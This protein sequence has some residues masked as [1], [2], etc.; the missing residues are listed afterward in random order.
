[1]ISVCIHRRQ[2]APRGRWEKVNGRLVALMNTA[3]SSATSANNF[4]RRRMLNTFSR[5]S[6]LGQYELLAP[7]DNSRR[8]T[9]RHTRHWCLRTRLRIVLLSAFLVAPV[10]LV[11]TLNSGPR[12]QDVRLFEERLPQ[13]DTSNI[14]KEGRYLRFEGMLTGKGFNNVLQE[15]WVTFVL[16]S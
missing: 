9:R 4:F 13:H 15:R 12:Y 11:L 5:F 16:F 6:N 2:E 3:F 1:M 8:H 10:C 14:E 7:N